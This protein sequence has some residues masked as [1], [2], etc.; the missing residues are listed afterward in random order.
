MGHS[1]EKTQDLS[2]CE[3]SAAIPRGG[4]EG[5]T[6]DTEDEIIGDIVLTFLAHLFILHKKLPS[7]HSEPLKV[8]QS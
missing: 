5:L 3:T 4:W 1:D 6:F 8:G 7:A 2:A